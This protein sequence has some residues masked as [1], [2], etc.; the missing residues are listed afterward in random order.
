MVFPEDA[1]SASP[2]PTST[3]T[4]TPSAASKR[5]NQITFFLDNDNTMMGLVKSGNDEGFT[6]Q[7]GVSYLRWLKNDGTLEFDATS[8]IYTKH[9]QAKWDNQGEQMLK[10]GEITRWQ[11]EYDSGGKIPVHF[12][13]VTRFKAA[14]T[15][16][17]SFYFKGAVGVEFRKTSAE[18]GS[19]PPAA[20]MQNWWHDTLGIYKYKYVPADGV[21]SSVTVTESGT[22]IEKNGYE[23]DER[24]KATSKVSVIGEAAVGKNLT[25]FEG[26]C[27]LQLEA[28]VS[29]SS[30]SSQVIGPNSYGS[31]SANLKG[32]VIRRKNGQARL[33]ASTGGAL[34]YFP[35]PNDRDIQKTGSSGNVSLASHHSVGKK[36]NSLQPFFT[37][38]FPQGRQ[39]FQNMNDKDTI[40]RIG[41][42]YQFGK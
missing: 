12:V 42:R 14:Y 15:S 28:G 11:R 35:S 33:T 18:G 24:L 7:M 19:L 32:D 10:K 34:F 30:E 31:V 13:D 17:K 6:H 20:A 16:G 22:G 8:A 36:G 9:A 38:Y 4:P 3:S 37:F 41:L 25:F 21:D 26:R 39:V 23:S 29:V 40:Q 5:A 1:N 27:T 2:N